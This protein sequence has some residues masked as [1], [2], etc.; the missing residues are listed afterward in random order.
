MGSCKLFAMLFTL[1]AS[2]TIPD[3]P[4][5]IEYDKQKISFNINRASESFVF[6]ETSLEIT[7]ET[8]SDTG[9][10]TAQ[11]ESMQSA[12]GSGATVEYRGKA[13]VITA[14][15]VCLP[16]AYDPYLKAMSWFAAIK[17]EVYG[18]GYFGNASRFTIVA[19]NLEKDVCI[20]KPDTRWI[21]PRLKLAKKLP[22]QGA[23]V[24]TISAPFGIFRPGMVLAFDGYLA[25][26][27]EEGD[28]LISAPTKPGTSGSAILDKHERVIGIVH[29]AF[30]KMESIGIGTPVEVIH[31]LFDE[32]D[33]LEK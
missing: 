21:S 9:E 18:H 20:L 16:Q 1:L 4:S 28:I 31:D 26:I 17:N 11:S 24:F 22:K 12:L 6:L 30:I 5:I 2:C 33:K 27:D 7:Q 8:C 23:K 19:V 13:Y 14:G 32:L 15:H 29:S 10:C 3:V 25:G